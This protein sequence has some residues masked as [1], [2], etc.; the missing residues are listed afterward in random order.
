[1]EKKKS[2]TQSELTGQVVYV[3]AKLGYSRL[4]IEEVFRELR[5]AF[6]V[7]CKSYVFDASLTAGR[8]DRKNLLP[9]IDTQKKNPNKG[10]P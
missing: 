5:H 2:L 9:T 10:T 1:M 6:N 3:M 4:Q 7:T 8:V